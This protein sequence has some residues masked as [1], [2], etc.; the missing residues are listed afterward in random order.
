VEPCSTIV[1]PP[2]REAAKYCFSKLVT[3]SL[4]LIGPTS[5]KY[6]FLHYQ[7]ILCVTAGE[8]LTSDYLWWSKNAETLLGCSSAEV[9]MALVTLNLTLLLEIRN[10]SKVIP[11]SFSSTRLIYPTHKPASSRFVLT[12]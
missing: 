8:P 1:L 7:T 6:F 9:M 11:V 4:I 12:I 3:Q 10:K 5:I 2:P